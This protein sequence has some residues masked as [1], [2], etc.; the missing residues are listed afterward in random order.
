MVQS[1][2]RA[3]RAK[4]NDYAELDNGG[5]RLLTSEHTTR[6]RAEPLEKVMSGALYVS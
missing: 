6:I 1:R 2:Q 5:L 3:T 4:K